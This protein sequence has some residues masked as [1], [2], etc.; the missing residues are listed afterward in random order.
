MP[1]VDVT[2]RP[3]PLGRL[4]RWGKRA[5]DLLLAALLLAMVV[6]AVLLIV[7]RNAFDSG[8][9]WGDELLRILVLW[10]CL[11]GSIA[12]SRDD[13]HLAIDVVSRF[14]PAPFQSL[15]RA[16]THFF[17]A[18]IC[19]TIAWYAWKF[20]RIEAEFGA[21]VL[22]QWPSWAVQSI[23]PVGFALIAYRY[24]MHG[25]RRLALLVKAPRR[26]P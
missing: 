9:V 11:V 3:R 22:G 23:L 16:L 12:A 26:T 21:R 25:L 6:L 8:I 20:V 10:L 13:N 19:A 24:L 5:E 18:A 7:L 17:T 14:L 1:E 15:A 4:W 2:T